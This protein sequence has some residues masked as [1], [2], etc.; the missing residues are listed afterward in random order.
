MLSTLKVSLQNVSVT[1]KCHQDR[2]K[3][4]RLRNLEDAGHERMNAITDLK[5]VTIINLLIVF[6][7]SSIP[8][9]DC[10]RIYV[11]RITRSFPEGLYF[12]HRNLLLQGSYAP[13]KSWHTL[14]FN[15]GISM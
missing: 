1:V 4:K 12:F 15:P 5:W 2:S 6:F 7:V 13:W 3:G 9:Y 10:Y 11:Q 8:T 14:H